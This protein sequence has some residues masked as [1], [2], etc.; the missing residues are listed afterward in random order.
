MLIIEIFKSHLFLKSFELI[1]NLSMYMYSYIYK[2][3]E[4]LVYIF[5][6]FYLLRNYS[7]V[8][9]LLYQFVHGIVMELFGIR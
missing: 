9:S 4:I 3:R 6:F 2:V 8:K 5:Y 7:L 1:F